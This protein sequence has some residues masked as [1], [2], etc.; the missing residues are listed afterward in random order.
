MPL[1]FFSSRRRHTR[2]PRDWSSDVCSSDLDIGSGDDPAGIEGPR[3]VDE[4][5]TGVEVL[6]D[7]HPVGAEAAFGEKRIRPGQRRRRVLVPWEPEPARGAQ[8]R[9]LGLSRGRKVSRCAS[10]G[11]LRLGL[12]SC[13]GLIGVVLL[14]L[15][16]RG[17]LAALLAQSAALLCW[18]DQY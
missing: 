7:E 11:A 8:C 10:F 18:G 17:R 14:G 4:R 16:L 15:E 3:V 5:P 9:G 12:R 13:R 1:F 6:A 2:W